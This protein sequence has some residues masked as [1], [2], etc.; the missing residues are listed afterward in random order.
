MLLHLEGFEDAE[1]PATY[2]SRKYPG[3]GTGLLGWVDGRFGGKCW[4][5]YNNNQITFNVDNK[6][7]V[8]LG[9]AYFLDNSLDNTDRILCDF[10]D[11]TTT[12][13][14][15]KL[16]TKNQIKIFRGSILINTINIQVSVKTWQYIE[17][18]VKINNTTGSYEIRK[19]GVVLVNISGIDT[20]ETAN[21]YI[22]NI[23][24]HAKAGAYCYIDD[25]YILDDTGSQNNNF[26]GDIKIISVKPNGDGNTFNFNIYPDAG[27]Y[28]YQDVDDG[29]QSDDDTTYVESTTVGHIDLF[30]Y[31]NISNIG[32]IFGIEIYSDTK[33]SDA[34]NYNLKTRLRYSGSENTDGGQA[35]TASYAIYKRILDQNPIIAAAWTDMIFNTTEFGVE[36]G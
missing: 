11:S 25:V 16:D 3:S 22:N 20:Q 27:E 21:A 18:K 4:R 26:L 15:I 23:R 8:I 31:E 7:T 24:I 10:R 30:N 34:T 6:Q 28:H 5:S 13:L 36:V 32:D 19:D 33:E 35:L 9:F 29:T 2:I 12:Q 14:V 17:V 1:T